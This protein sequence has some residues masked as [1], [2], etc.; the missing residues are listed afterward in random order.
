MKI[1][2]LIEHSLK[3]YDN[4]GGVNNMFNICHELKNIGHDVTIIIQNF[5]KKNSL[6]EKTMK[7][8]KC[9]NK[10]F[11]NYII[12][13]CI[14]IDYDKLLE[15]YVQKINIKKEDI[16]IVTL[17]DYIKLF[18]NYNQNLII[19]IH[20]G[21]EMYMKLH[22]PMNFIQHINHNFPIIFYDDYWKSISLDKYNIKNNKKFDDEYLIFTYFT[23]NDRL[24]KNISSETKNL[25]SCFHIQKNKYNFNL[26]HDHFNSIHLNNYNLDKSLNIL[27]KTKFFYAYDIHSLYVNFALIL[28]NNIIIPQYKNMNKDEFIDFYKKDSN[29]QNNKFYDILKKYLIYV[30]NTEKLNIMEY[31]EFDETHDYLFDNLINKFH[32]FKFN[33]YEELNKDTISRLSK[34]IN[35]TNNKNTNKYLCCKDII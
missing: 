23:V 25:D 11:D 28:K 27:E 13:D 4:I 30:E 35:D 7:F 21:S 6:N 1:Y 22:H 18:Q 34:L 24:K 26:I 32:G 15:Y 9:M 33:S 14:D 5:I 17:W 10:I 2:V 3:Y 12:L 19:Y 16:I 31:I 29:R 20:G 8:I